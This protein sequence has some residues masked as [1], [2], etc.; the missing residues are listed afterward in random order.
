MRLKYRL[1]TSAQHAALLKHVTNVQFEIGSDSE[2]QVNFDILYILPDQFY[3]ERE[4]SVTSVDTRFVTPTMKSMLTRKNRLMRSG[5]LDDASALTKRTHRD[6][7]GHILHQPTKFYKDRSNRYGNIA[8]FVMFQDGGRRHFGFSKIRNFNSR[9]AVR[10]QCA[11]LYQILSKSVK[12]LHR[13]SDLTFF[14]KMA[15]VRHLGFVGRRLGPPTT[16]LNRTVQSS[17]R[18]GIGQNAQNYVWRSGKLVSGQ[19]K[20]DGLHSRTT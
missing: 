10:G 8:I 12:R 4:I 17:R 6:S 15:A 13:Y 1:R 11:S 5:R 19:S 9:S 7:Q 3:T 16:T 14:F 2:I 20:E 18:D